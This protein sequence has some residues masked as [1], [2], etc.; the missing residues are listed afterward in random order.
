MMSWM[1]SNKEVYEGLPQ[2][3]NDYLDQFGSEDYKLV[4]GHSFDDEAVELSNAVVYHVINKHTG[5][6]EFQGSFLASAIDCLKA[7]QSRLTATLVEMKNDRAP[8]IIN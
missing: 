4:I 5:V 6:V 3:S 1:D 8:R 2:A 7:L